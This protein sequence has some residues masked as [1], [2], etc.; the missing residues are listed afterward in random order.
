MTSNYEVPRGIK[1]LP[2]W[3][4]V[5]RLI[6]GIDSPDNYQSVKHWCAQC[7]NPPPYGEKLR[8]AIN[9]AMGG[10][11]I[12]SIRQKDY[13]VGYYADTRYLYVNRGDTYDITLVYDTESDKFIVASW[14][15]LVERNPD[16]YF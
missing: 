5:S 3:D 1:R 16:R 13:L 6:R 8:E 15:N 2:N 14:G 12:E 7:Y 9:E 11:G 10:H 4:A